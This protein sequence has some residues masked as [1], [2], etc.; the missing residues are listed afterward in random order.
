MRLGRRS[1]RMSAATDGDRSSM[2]TSVGG[3]SSAEVTRTAV[4]ILPPWRSMSAARAR[5]IAPDPPSATT[6][7]LAWEAAISINPTALVM[8]RSRRE[9]ACAAIPAQSALASWVFQARP[10]TVAGVI[11]PTPKR[12]RVNGCSGIR[13]TGCEA[14]AKRSSKCFVGC[15]NTRRHR[16]PS[17]P[18][19]ST[20]W[21]SDLYN[22]PAVPSSRGCA[23]SAFGCNQ[24]SPFAPRSSWA[25]KGEPA[26]M[27]WMAE[28]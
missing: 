10:T 7:P 22:T 21:S 3:R 26:A 27:G 2:T 18:S 28:Q 15:S 6:H 9:N 20:V 5:A 16:W 25:K 8:G 24:F 4:S 11:A 19:A 14:S 1:P 13:R 17:S 12:A 23:Q